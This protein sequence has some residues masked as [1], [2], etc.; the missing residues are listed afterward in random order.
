MVPLENYEGEGDYGF[1]KKYE[2]KVLPSLT[3]A[4]KNVIKI[5][6][7]KGRMVKL[8]NVLKQLKS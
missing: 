7:L 5:K 2:T 1:G 6:T 4:D 3:L 8:K